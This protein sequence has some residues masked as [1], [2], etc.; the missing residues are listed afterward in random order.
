MGEVYHDRLK[1]TG[2]AFG[3]LLA[4]LKKDRVS[5]PRTIVYCH[6]YSMCADIYLY[7]LKN[8]G[9]E[10]T[11]PIDA[12]N[13]PKYRMVDMYTSV[14]DQPQKELIIELFTHQTHLRVVIATVA[15]GLGIDCPDV[16]Q[17][18]HVRMPEDIESYIQESGRAGRDGLCSLVTLLKSRS[19]HV[20]ERD[21]K[22]YCSNVT[23]C[24]RVALFE[25]MENYN[26][27]EAKSKCMC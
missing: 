9:D 11:E 24:R 13:V 16:R 1:V 10:F 14:T 21:I 6:S 23:K 7:L 22:D 26:Y 18:F 15:F 19:Y 20:C 4:R 12:P 17:V 3:P 27:L 2:E 8:L 5:T 25:N